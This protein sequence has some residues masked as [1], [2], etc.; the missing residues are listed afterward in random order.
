MNQRMRLWV[1]LLTISS[2]EAVAIAFAGRSREKS[3]GEHTGGYSTSNGR[4][5]LP[6]GAALFL[7]NA[8]EADRTGKLYPDGLDPDV[9]IT[10]LESRPE[11]D[12]DQALAAAE[13]WLS[14]EGSR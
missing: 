8:I 11:E 10:E 4:Y 5:P 12:Q 6:D 9:V 13:K 1:L 14:E 3:F 7:C 2:G